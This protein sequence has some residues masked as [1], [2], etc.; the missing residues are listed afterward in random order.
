[1]NPQEAL[2]FPRAFHFNNIYRLEL[3]VDKNIE[4]QLKKNGH[5]LLV[6]KQKLGFNV[7][8]TNLWRSV[9]KSL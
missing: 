2:D 9:G 1:M 3:G 6:G 5:D 7:N 4:D 8:T